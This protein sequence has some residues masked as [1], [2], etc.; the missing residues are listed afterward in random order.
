MKKHLLP[1]LLALSSI[2]LCAFAAS[3]A[4]GR[5]E[6]ASMTI[7]FI[8]NFGEEG[9]GSLS[10]ELE[11]SKELMIVMKTLSDVEPDAICDTIFEYAYEDWERTQQETDGALTC[12]AHNT[13]AD[14][15]E[16]ES[17]IEGDFGGATFSRLE[18]ADGHLY[19][20]LAPHVQGSTFEGAFGNEINVDVMAYW[21]L[22]MPGEVVDSNADTASGKTLTW[23]LLKL[24][25]SSHIRAESKLGGSGFLGLDPAL[26][27]LGG[28]GL[29]GCCCVALL[30][31]GGALF[32]FLR[33]KN[34]PAAAG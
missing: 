14:L 9:S 3:P 26:T 13:F 8:T 15:D 12:E 21:I 34:N 10:Y 25:S 31:A 33:R 7:R 4:P 19:Y 11:L 5:L 30:I 6:N 24:N 16:L 29:M 32:F 28:I 20:D 17:L 27:I 2:L 23:D 22:K 1:S 18:I